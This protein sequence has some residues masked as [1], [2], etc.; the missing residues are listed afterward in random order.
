[1]SSILVVEDNKGMAEL[2]YKVL[3][4]EGFKVTIASKVKEAIRNLGPDVLAVITDLKLPDGDGIEVVLATKEAFPFTPIVVITAYG[5]IESA[6]KAV[7]AGAYDFITKPF[8]PYQLVGLIKKAIG[9]QQTRKEN[10]ILRHELERLGLPSEIVGVSEKWKEVMAKVEKVAHLNTTVLILGESGT[11]K[12]LI[13]RVLHL[14]GPR[15]KGPFVAINC[16]AIPKDLMENELF[17]HEKGAFTGAIDIK[18]GK[19]EL[20]NGGTLFLDEVGDMEMALQAKLLRV[21]DQREIERV[22]GTRSIKVDV[23]IV[24]ASNKNLEKQVREG[25]FREDLYF[26][27]NVFPIQVPPLRERREDI[28]ILV[29]FFVKYFAA[30]FGKGEPSI[31]EDVFSFLMGHEWPGNV[32]ELKN[33][34]E[35]AMINLEGGLLSL[36]HFAP[37]GLNDPNPR[38][39]SLHDSLSH[40]TQ[41]H[42]RERILEALREAQG[43]KS[44]AARLLQVSYKTLLSKLKQYGIS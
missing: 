34:V 13:A 23:R 41:L 22:G 8:D 18:P 40:I 21:M 25:K 2:L 37:F 28:P 7:K 17:G 20:A 9:E 15:A 3:S 10:L 43:N 29:R 35:R 30:Q 24:A 4:D 26:R 38:G 16:A 32:R 19:F 39:S 1:M 44:Q 36:R 12:E 27:L 6:V 31:S 33:H 42:E 11:G 14:K 5:S